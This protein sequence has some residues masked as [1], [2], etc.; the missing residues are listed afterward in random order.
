MDAETRRQP[1]PGRQAA[2]LSP[3]PR[4]CDPGLHADL[5]LVDREEI[6]RHPAAGHHDVLPGRCTAIL[7]PVAQHV[8]SGRDAVELRG[9]HCGQLYDPVPVCG[10][11]ERDRATCCGEDRGWVVFDD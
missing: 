9:S 8:L 3:V 2:I 10:A 5:R 7:L 11:G 4:H 1:R 6:R